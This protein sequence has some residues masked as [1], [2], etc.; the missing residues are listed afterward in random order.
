MAPFPATRVPATGQKES[1]A[2]GSFW[3][4]S[5]YLAPEAARSGSQNTIVPNIDLAYPIFHYALNTSPAHLP[6]SPYLN[7]QE[8]F[9][10][11]C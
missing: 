3:T 9:C 11:F 4:A 1:L 6:L 7:Y 2:K 5:V 10:K 8:S